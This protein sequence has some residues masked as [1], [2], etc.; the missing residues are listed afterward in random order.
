[1]M[2]D[3]QEKMAGLLPS[4]Y[5]FLRHKESSYFQFIKYVFCGGITFVV[6][7]MVFYAMAWLIL[8]SL[9]MNDP[10]GTIVGL[11]GWS[12]KAVS[13]ETLLRNYV[14]NKV[15]AFLA[16]NTV[17]YIT[18]VIFVFNAGRHQRAKEVGL[19]Y[20]LSTLSFVVFTVLSRF[21]I[22]QFGWQVSWSYF[23]VF[24]LAMVVNF[25]MRKKLVFKG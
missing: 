25:T 4:F 9:R 13:E 11:F 7:V 15:V 6:D 2:F 17:A 20:L 19:F 14:L 5:V 1:M 18:N 24:A 3:W 22:G 10:F 8:P 12:I 16:S 23:F 21:L